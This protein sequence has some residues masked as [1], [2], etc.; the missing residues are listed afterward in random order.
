MQNNITI[1]AMHLQ[2]WP[3][4]AN[5]YQEGIQTGIATF[6]KAVPSFEVWDKKNLTVGRLVA[7]L[8]EEIMG[9]TTLSPVSTRYVYRGIAE[10]SIYIKK[11]H[12][13]RKIGQQLM[14]QLIQ[15]SEQH[16]FWTLQSSI[17]PE[18]VVSIK[19]HDKMGFRRIG[20]REKVGCLDGVW[21]DN[22]LF[23]RRSRLVG[24]ALGA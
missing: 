5:I 14:Q 2:D 13:G 22:I 6:E 20:F 3:A 10:V 1:K 16:G 19:L 9:W 23:E 24:V 4:V 21:K 17:M 12:R 8:Q 15:D 11:G 7:L 18:N